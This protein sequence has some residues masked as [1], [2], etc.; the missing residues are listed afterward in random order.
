MPMLVPCAPRDPG[1]D[2][3]EQARD[4]ALRD[5]AGVDRPIEAGQDD[6]EVVAADPRHRIGIVDDALQAAR[7]GAQQGVAGRMAERVVDVLEV[8]EVELQHRHR[9]PVAPRLRHREAETIEEQRAIGQL[10]QEIVVRQPP[11][12]VLGALAGRMSRIATT[13][14]NRPP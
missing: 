2:R 10:G 11:D 5:V 13:R 14:A 9:P 6:R 12:M 7:T 1:A 4:D 3:L 8:V